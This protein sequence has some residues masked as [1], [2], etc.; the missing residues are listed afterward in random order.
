[1][2]EIYRSWRAIAD[3]HPGRV[4]VGEVWLPDA[5]RLARYV[6][7]GELHTVFNFP[8]LSCPW[9]ASELRQV[10]DRTLACRATPRRPGCCPTTTSTGS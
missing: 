3:E 2:H 7:P 1:M 6:N 10:I 5:A 8:Y 9:Y 4:L